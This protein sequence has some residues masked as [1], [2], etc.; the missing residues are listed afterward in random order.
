MAGKGQETAEI[1]QKNTSEAL[2]LSPGEL[3]TGNNTLTFA[4]FWAFI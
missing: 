1:C 4:V 2:I 3:D